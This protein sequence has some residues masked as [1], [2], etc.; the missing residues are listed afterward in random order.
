MVRKYQIGNYPPPD[1]LKRNYN[2]GFTLAEVLIALVV[3]GIIAAITVPTII[4][5]V[6]ERERT[7]KVKKV[8]ATLANAMT[9]VKA[10][11]GDMDFKVVNDNNS[12]IKSWYDTYLKNY[13]ITTKVCYNQK[14]CWNTDNTKQLNGNIV[15]YNHPGFGVGDNIVTAILNDGT[16][17]NIDAYGT[18]YGFGV[19]SNSGTLIIFFDI[20]GSKK[21]NTIGKDIFATVFT[22][23]GFVPAYK[24]KT[25]AQIDADCSS[26]GTGFSCI[27]KYLNK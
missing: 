8:Y 6:E 27:Q 24:D 16:F 26:S 1:A 3:I 11:G 18:G 19:N 9:R 12:N 7:A 5:N 14:G 2:N 10:D 23:N 13:L 25:K 21:P 4:S 17:I 15:N 20:N 22:E